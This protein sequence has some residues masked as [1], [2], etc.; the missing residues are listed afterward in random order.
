MTP[1]KTIQ[2]I[3]ASSGRADLLL[4]KATPFEDELLHVVDMAEK[5]ISFVAAGET[6]KAM[7]W[8][9]FMQGVLWV[10]GVPLDELKDMNRPDADVEWPTVFP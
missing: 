2:A 5:A 1:Q 6:E 8:L 4:D 3:I 9:G 10:A 7:R